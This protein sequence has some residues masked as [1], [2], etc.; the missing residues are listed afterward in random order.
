L[1]SVSYQGSGSFFS[2]VT[3]VII[4][5]ALIQFYTIVFYHFLK[6]TCHCD[7]V[8]ALKA[9]NSRKTLFKRKFKNNTTED[10]KNMALINI[11]ERAYNYTE[12][13]DGLV[14]DDFK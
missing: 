4:S 5:L 6:Y 14:S 7:T 3:N 8:T 12:Y 11:P 13:Q 1:Y 2:I 10:F 9:F